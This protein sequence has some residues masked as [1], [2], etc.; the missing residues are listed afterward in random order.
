MS[1]SV[2]RA[3]LI[4]INYLKNN[5][6]RLSGCIE[7]VKN[8]QTMLI[9]AYGY[10]PENIVV[11]RDDIPTKNPTRSNI[12]LALQ[13]IATVSGPNDELWIHYSGH[14]SQI[15]D[16]NNDEMDKLDETIVPVD[17]MTAGMIN[18][19]ELFNIVRTIKCKACLVF[20]SCHSG[21]I[22]DLQYSINYNS[23]SFSR[24]VTT[25][26]AIAN[27]NIIVLS[28]CRDTQ[29]S[30]DSFDS[31]VNEFGGAMTI[32]LLTVLRKNRHSAD[33]MKIYNDLCADLVNN[34]FGQIPVLSSTVVVPTWV[35][36]RPP[37]DK[38]TVFIEPG[39]P[40]AASS[41][42][43]KPANSSVPLNKPSTSNS[44][45]N[46]ILTINLFS[47]KSSMKPKPKFGLIM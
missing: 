39:R 42:P 19:D 16:T 37:P 33:I 22:C 17:Y 34:K 20:D 40:A 4:G 23:G 14:G 1:T 2:K 18:D 10:P 21:S 27:P 44:K 36:M 12:L 29:T 32:S 30:E 11:L 41:I 26:K 9:D 8:I 6:A 15:R 47:K 3:L 31:R 46:T 5:A 38:I 43:S 25:N 24:S 28:G 35:F 7:D 45:K 13:V